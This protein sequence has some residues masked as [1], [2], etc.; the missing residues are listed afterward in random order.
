EHASVAAMDPAKLPAIRAQ[1]WTLLQ[2]AQLHSDL[3][4]TERPP[5]EEFDDFLLHVDGYLCEVKDVLIRDGLHILGAA[6]TGEARVNL[7]LAVLRATQVWGGRHGAL[8][9]L[10]AALSV[11]SGVSDVDELEALARK[12]VS[13]CDAL[14]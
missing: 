2:A 1:I 11:H 3:G 4:V 13:G 5:D 7:V 6:P 14:D 8:P 9:G 10:R 12:L